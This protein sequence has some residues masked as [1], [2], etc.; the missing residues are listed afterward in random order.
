MG[1]L[2]RKPSVPIRFLH[3]MI[4]VADLERSVAFYTLALGMRELRRDIY[5]L[6]R[7]TLVFV[8]YGEEDYG[9]IIELTYNWDARCYEHGRGFGHL[10]V[11]VVDI[12]AAIL[13]MN[14]MGVKIIRSPGPME[15]CA[16]GARKQEVIAFVEDPD[17]YRIELIEIS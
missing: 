13:R 14:A 8:G 15:F 12:G 10:A 4:R 7:F 2:E 17:G 11:G 5:P 9:A 3:T 16:A 1:L 6:G